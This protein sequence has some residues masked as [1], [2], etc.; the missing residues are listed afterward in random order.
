MK[1]LCLALCLFAALDALAVTNIWLDSMPLDHIRQNWKTAARNRSVDG[2]PLKIA[3]KVYE[4][5][6][7]SHSPGEALYKLDGKTVAFGAVVGIDDEAEEG[8]SVIFR[9]YADDKLVAETPELG[10]KAGN[11]G[12]ALLKADLKG[13]KKVELEIDKIDGEECDHADWCKAVF[14]AEDGAVIEPMVRS[15]EQLGILSPKIPKTPRINGPKVFGVGPDHPIIYRLPV[16][17]ERPMEF[18]AENLPEGTSFDAKTGILTG[19][20]KKAG[21][22]LITFKAKNA[23]GE[24]ERTLKLT[25]GDKIALT[26]PMGWN[27][28]NCFASKVSQKDIEKAAEAMVK[29]GLAD[30]GWNYI[31]ID[32]FWQN[33]PRE[34]HD[35]TLMGPERLPDGTIAANKRFPDMKGLADYVHSLGLRIGLYS[36]PG[37]ETCG[38]CVGSW[39]HEEQDAKT[40]ADWGYDYLKYDWCSYSRVATGEGKVYWTKPYT[41]M[42]KAL[43]S[44]NR[45]I[46]FSLCQYGWGDVSKWGN[47]VNGSCWRTTGD[48]TDTY[49]SMFGILQQQVPLW[50]YAGPDGWNDPD[51]L[52]VGKVGWGALHPTR[53]TQNE[54]YTHMSMWAILCSPLLIGCDLT[55]LDEFTL[56][57]LTNDEVIEVNQDELGAQAARIKEDAVSEIWAKPMSDGSIVMAFF[58]KSKRPPK[59]TIVADMKSLG[60]EG[61]WLARDL[62]RQQDIGIFSKNYSCEVPGHATQLV[63]F[64]PKPDGKLV[65]GLTDI[66]N[67]KPAPK[68]EE[69]AE[70][71]CPDCPKNKKE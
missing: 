54:Q 6:V 67:V 32:D 69:E 36:S 13:A 33:R 65:E 42:G 18:S 23:L 55:D 8:A 14:I 19:S 44:Q 59:S 57:L 56:S 62:W 37:P 1:K 22:Y 70:I 39:E 52:I 11:R 34:K 35:E 27:S 25:V 28:W 12:P 30:H 41:Q 24:T 9:V 2:N 15:S 21:D 60:L 47:E 50:I 64:F 71:Q 58:N 7:G 16:S 26:P 63:R 46:L 5:G 48:I 61:H 43:K 20:V 51:M 49:D 53:L 29:S 68:S 40:Y 3:G 10:D 31:N 45:D 4:R 17:G 38:C 66:R